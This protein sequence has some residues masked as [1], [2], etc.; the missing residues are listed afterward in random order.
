[1]G[2]KEFGNLLTRDYMSLYHHHLFKVPSPLTITTQGTK[3]PAMTP[4]GTNYFQ[5]A[6]QVEVI[7]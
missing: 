2:Q 3:L 6:E 5:T 1:V 7:K 4:W